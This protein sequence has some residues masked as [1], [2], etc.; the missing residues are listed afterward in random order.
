[1]NTAPNFQTEQRNL[2]GVHN[3]AMTTSD[4]LH[5]R[6][7]KASLGSVAA[8]ELLAIVMRVRWEGA[9]VLQIAREICV[10]AG[11]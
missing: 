8:A 2:F 10:D 7:R 5:D 9:S 11:A 1:M 3:I 6:L 4:P